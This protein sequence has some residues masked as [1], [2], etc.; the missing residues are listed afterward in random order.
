MGVKRLEDLV[1]FQQAGAFKLEVYAIV[2]SHP[3]ANRDWRY[4]DQLFDAL[5]ASRQTWR[6]AG[7]VLA[8]ET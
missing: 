3:A 1:A 6:R 8:R 5:Q 7:G 2:Q 4:R